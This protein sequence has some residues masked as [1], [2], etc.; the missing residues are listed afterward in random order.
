MRPRL[1]TRDDVAE[2]LQRMDAS[3]WYA[4]LGPQEVE[5]RQRFAA[6]VGADERQV[7]TASSATLALQGA[8]TLSPAQRWVV[9][10]FTFPA[11]PAAVLQAGA[12]L[13]FADICA[14][15]WWLD[16]AA[17]RGTDPTT[18]VVPVAPFGAPLDLGRWDP[19][20]EVVIDAAASLGA[21]VAALGEL[22]PTWAVVFSL[23][24]TKCL[25]AGEGGLVVFGDPDRAERFR[26][27]SNFGFSE[28]RDAQM[29]P[30]N[31]KLAE[32]AAVYA[33]AS[34][35]TWD[36]SR[37]EW[38]AARSR[39]DELERVHGLTGQPGPRAGVNP[40]WIVTFRDGH[41]ADHCA[42]T[43]ARHGID[44]RRWWSYG[45]HGMP[46]FADQPADPLP[47]TGAVA[48]ATLGLPM[49][50]DLGEAEAQQVSVALDEARRS[51]GI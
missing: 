49:F 2:R 22:P 15:D 51:G 50:R 7:A 42:A 11:T 27:W 16:P 4:N 23:H 21:D 13:R 5:L 26:M 28:V 3:G 45:C 9:P 33:H 43:L 18:G 48:A 10:S 8:V 14:A 46:A 24:A 19:A 47:V 34:L 32:V 41:A 31:A 44:T 17:W 40:Y 37:A 6:F 38:Q 35:D 12:H 20:R 30:S 25:P 29:L 36:Q 39:T 1:P